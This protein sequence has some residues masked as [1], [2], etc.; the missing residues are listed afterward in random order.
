M[1]LRV[2]KF[3]LGNWVKLFWVPVR[4]VHRTRNSPKSRVLG[5]ETKISNHPHFPL[6]ALSPLKPIICVRV[7]Y[8]APFSEIFLFFYVLFNWK[9]EQRTTLL[10]IVR[11]SFSVSPATK[12]CM[13][14]SIFT[15]CV[16]VLTFKFR[17]G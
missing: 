15:L 11:T 10:F 16:E 1:S 4:V 13:I 9:L 12:L 8:V 17:F 3:R 6:C 2:Q 7:R 14:L 5:T